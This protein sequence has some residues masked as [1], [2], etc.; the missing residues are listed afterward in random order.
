M[1]IAASHH[2]PQIYVWLDA[3]TNYLTVGG[4]PDRTPSLD[5]H[6]IG[7]DI[8]KCGACC[9]AHRIK[10]CRFHAIYWPAFLMACEL[11]LPQR[12]ICHSHWTVDGFKA[13]RN[14]NACRAH[15]SQMS[16]SRGNVVDPTAL[17]QQF[18]VDPIRYFLL[19]EGRLHIDGGR[20]CS[21]LR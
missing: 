7:K 17:L 15:A 3:L 20:F 5:C 8:L 9:C 4:Y 21:P 2:L 1:H 6:V 18:G 19:R 16:K 10:L 12:I 13:L 14:C 11:P